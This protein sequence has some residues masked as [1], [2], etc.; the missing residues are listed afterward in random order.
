M[1]ILTFQV[2]GTCAQPEEH[3]NKQLERLSESD[4]GCEDVKD[5]EGSF[6][7]LIWIGIAIFLLV[8]IIVLVV[9]WRKKPWKHFSVVRHRDHRP[10][11]KLSRTFSGDKKD[12]VVLQQ[13]D[14]SNDDERFVPLRGLQYADPEYANFDMNS[15]RSEHLYSEVA[16]V[17]ET[18]PNYSIPIPNTNCPD[19]KVSVI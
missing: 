10:K 12:I 13:T 17:K 2:L 14:I 5:G 9:I 6:Q 3:A 16:E 1:T 15:N 7:W 11:K 4:Y 18:G 19:V 8:F